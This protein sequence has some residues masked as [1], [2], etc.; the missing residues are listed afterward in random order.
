MFIGI[1]LPITRRGFLAPTPFVGMLDQLSATAAAALSPSRALLTSYVGSPLIDLR[2]SSDNGTLTINAGS[3]GGADLAGAGYTAWAGADSI[4]VTKVYD[5]TGNGK[6]WSQGTAGSQPRFSP[7]G[8]G[9]NSRAYMYQPTTTQIMS[10][11]L[12]WGVTG[13]AD[14][15]LV[16]YG[17]FLTTGGTFT[18]IA[19]VGN[20]SSSSCIG[21]TSTAWW[22]GGAFQ[23]G[24][25]GG[26]VDT[27]WHSFVKRHN[28]SNTYGRVDGSAVT[29]SDL[30]FNLSS[31]TLAFGRYNGANQS[32][33][34]A[35]AEVIAFASDIGATD[36][37]TIEA[38][39]AAFYG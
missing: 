24:G 22:F 9:T 17:K 26:S 28:A 39:H 16:A 23:G 13:D 12:G 2:R 36:A 11:A 35:A 8:A 31:D 34:A 21:S 30:A 27:S 7:T 38:N 15:S 20:T 6:H 1:G 5:Q 4:F 37:A 18:G 25:T 14:H 33:T 10:V 32:D 29:S 19:G 3:A